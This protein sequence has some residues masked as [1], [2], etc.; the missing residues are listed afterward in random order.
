MPTPDAFATS[1]DRLIAWW[2]RQFAIESFSDPMTA[3]NR[4]AYDRM[5]KFAREAIAWCRA[6]RLNPVFVY[7]PASAC[8]DGVFPEGFFRACVLD[9]VRDVAPDV[10]FFDYRSTP[11]LRAD[12]NFADALFL[13]RTG[14]VRLTALTIR[15]V[16]KAF[17]NCPATGHLPVR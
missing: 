3:K 11:E 16:R 7:P 2:R 10:P 1:R 5:V 6:E 4:A 14:S 15:D 17:A 9:F 13:N 12:R 8:F